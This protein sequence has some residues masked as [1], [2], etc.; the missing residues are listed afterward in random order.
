MAIGRNAI[1]KLAKANKPLHC[2]TFD[3][4]P[5]QPNGMG[6]LMTNHYATKAQA[7]REMADQ[8]FATVKRTYSTR[9]VTAVELAQAQ[10]N[11]FYFLV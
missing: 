3:F 4:G 5:K 6:G 11:H 8:V 7:E 9:P 2:V 10:N 1:L